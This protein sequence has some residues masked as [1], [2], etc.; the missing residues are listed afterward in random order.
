MI[1][2]EDIWNESESF[3]SKESFSFEELELKIKIY[4]LLDST[5]LSE[6]DKNKAK[7]IAFGEILFTL[8]NL[9]LKDNINVFEALKKVLKLK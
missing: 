4:Q 7:E 8:T 5:N 3:H 2:F 9:S 1:H 6:E